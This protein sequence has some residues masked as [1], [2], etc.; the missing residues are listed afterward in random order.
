VGGTSE[1]T[2]ARP[3]KAAL[4]ALLLSGLLALVMLGSRGSHPGGDA[5][6]HQREVPA[7]AANDL[8]TILV[9]VYV[10]GTVVLLAVFYWLRGEGGQRRKSRWLNQVLLLCMLVVAAAFA[11]HVVQGRVADRLH[12]ATAPAQRN[13]VT[14]RRTPTLPDR[15]VARR[16]AQLDWVLAALIGGG[17]VLA[18]VVVRIRRRQAG[19]VVEDEQTVEEELSAAVGDA[20]DDLRREPDPRRAVIAAY[21]RMERVLA[22]HGQPRSASEAP[23]E[24]LAR[25]LLR[26]RV[27]PGA[28]EA[29][30]ELFERAKFSAH[31]IDPS[32]KERAIA[33]LVSVRDDL[34]A[35]AA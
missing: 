12:R 25:V 13:P 22:Q 19:D 30:T 8:L 6:L 35:L 5:Q 2:F 33:A 15:P 32:M 31:E 21:A 29:L 10:L 4:A 20:I 27:R 18:A 28:V 1:R 23:F 24:Y 17:L 9:A 7:Q 3:L 11:A 26:L 14:G 16:P 34:G